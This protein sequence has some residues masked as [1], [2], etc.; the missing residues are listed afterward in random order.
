[1]NESQAVNRLFEKYKDSCLFT[2]LKTGHVKM[3]NGTT[4]GDWSRMGKTIDPKSEEPLSLAEEFFWKHTAAAKELRTRI[5][6][7][8]KSELPP[9]PVSS[10]LTKFI[11]KNTNYSRDAHYL[12][13]VSNNDTV[14]ET[15]RPYWLTGTFVV[16][17]SGDTHDDITRAHMYLHSAAAKRQC[18]KLNNMFGYG[19]SRFDSYGYPDSVG[20]AGYSSVAP[21][22]VVVPVDITVA[23][24]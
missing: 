6:D 19:G 16:D 3:V 14:F 2:T 4:Y 5:A 13:P 15:A 1:M 24:K 18:T 20:K 8:R 12:K 7:W 9:L 21:T 10:T 23:E 22:Y 17:S 11:I